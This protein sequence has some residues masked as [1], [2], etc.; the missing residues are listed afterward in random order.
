MRPPFEIST[1]PAAR[2]PLSDQP[3]IPPDGRLSNLSSQFFRP[4]S[5]LTSYADRCHNSGVS[6]CWVRSPFLSPDLVPPTPHMLTAHHFHSADSPCVRRIVDYQAWRGVLNHPARHPCA[7]GASRRRSA[8]FHLAL[9]P[10][11]ASLWHALRRRP[12]CGPT[13]RARLESPVRLSQVPC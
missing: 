9:S 6:W 12:P 8:Y 10:P 11:R 3:R 4:L 2:L 5:R 1:F 13:P 7:S